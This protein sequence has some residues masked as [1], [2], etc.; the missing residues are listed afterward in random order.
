MN[1]KLLR[2]EKRLCSCCMEEHDVKIVNVCENTV[3]KNE[4]VE[5]MA[6]YFYCD[7]AEELYMDESMINRNDV[8]MKD[9]YRRK[10]GLLTSIEI[11]GVRSKYGT[12]QRDLCVLLGWGEKTITR[13]EGHQVQDKAHDSILKKLQHDPEWFLKLLK[14]AKEQIS[15]E[16]YRK[17]YDIALMSY[18]DTQDLY[19]RK[20]IEAQYAKYVDNQSY[21]G[22]TPLYL[23]KVVDVIRYFSNSAE[24]NSLYKV[25]LMKL[26]WY[27][28]FLAYK[29]QGSAI[30]GLVYQALPMGAVPIGHNSIIDLKGINYEEIDMGDVTAYKFYPSDNREYLYLQDD[31]KEILDIVISKLGKMQK[32]EIVNFMHREKA[33]I[34][35]AQRDII[36]YEYANNLQISSARR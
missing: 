17:Y 20:S 32:D 28:D 12:S 10:E 29:K 35:T 31:E 23:D 6:E 25:K 5:Y 14:E 8:R 30:T 4:K 9:A 33:Y 22:N 24:V 2:T 21:N 1:M 13:Y 15:K 19:L 3:F 36:K 16:S 18:E 34:E 7:A 27:A 11:S 26:M